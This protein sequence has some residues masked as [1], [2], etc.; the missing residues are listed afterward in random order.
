MRLGG[1]WQSPR[2]DRRP[3]PRPPPARGCTYSHVSRPPGDRSVGMQLPGE[4]SRRAQLMSPF[5]RLFSCLSCVRWRSLG[6]AGK[7]S[8]G[9]THSAS[10]PPSTGSPQDAD[11]LEDRMPGFGLHTSCLWVS[12][13]TLTFRLHRVTLCCLLS[14]SY[15]VKLAFASAVHS[16]Q[17]SV[18]N[19]ALKGVETPQ[20]KSRTR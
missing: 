8:W 6:V 17:K 2:W 9:T 3:Q 7:P 18:Q 15:P 4:A 20:H 5:A 19:E 13:I 11:N 14:S 1:A 12:P 10:W 16:A